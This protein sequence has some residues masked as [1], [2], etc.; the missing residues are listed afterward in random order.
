MLGGNFDI[1]DQRLWF[2]NRFADLTHGVEV[3]MHSLQEVP[4]LLVHRS[5]TV[6]AL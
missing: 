1:V 6:A 5:L 3:G 4:S 2:R